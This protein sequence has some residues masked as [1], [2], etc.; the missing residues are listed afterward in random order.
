MSLVKSWSTSA[1][2]NNSVSPNGFPEGMAPSGVNDSAREV[3]ASVRAFYEAIEFRDMGHT[4]TYVSATSFTIATDVTAYYPANRPLKITDSSTLYGIVSSSSYGAP[5]TTVNVTLDS[6]SLSASLSAVSV[7][8][9]DT[10]DPIH[11]NALRG[12]LPVANG[13]T[14]ATTAADARTNLGVPAAT[15][16]TLTTP[17]WSGTMTMTDN[18]SSYLRGSRYSAAFPYFY[19]EGSGAGAN[20]AGIILNAW[21]GA[22][23]IQAFQTVAGGAGNA[24]PR[25]DIGNSSD[26]SA[27]LRVASTENT[28]KF[29]VGIGTTS[30]IRADADTFTFRNG[31][32]TTLGTIGSTGA[33]TLS[34]SANSLL[35]SPQDGS[36]N[37]WTVYNP[38][39]DNIKLYNGSTDRLTIANDGTTTITNTLTSTKS[40]ASGYTRIGPNYCK[41]DVPIGVVTISGTTCTQTTALSGVSDAK[42][43]DLSFKIYVEAA[44]A[45]SARTNAISAYL[46]TDTTCAASTTAARFATVYEHVAVA[47][48]TTISIS[49]QTATVMSDTSGRTYVMS[50]SATASQPVYIYVEGYHD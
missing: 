8:V 9:L 18:N 25:V 21:N 24:Y 5:N 4:P 3:M 32:G 2:S 42:A 20:A 26:S 41:K 27:T 49:Y 11:V 40:C 17:T 46:P 35:L 14:G 47:A 10:G 30:E 37:T 6:G 7:G 34:G 15:S 33:L 39:G 45:V 19:I 28:A 48:G 16:G 50:S 38:T 44:N 31:S 22:A 13:G 12:A 23:S 1:G 36:G 29:S 43:I